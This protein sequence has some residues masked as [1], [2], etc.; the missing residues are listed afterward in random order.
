[1]QQHQQSVKHQVY[2][3]GDKEV[4][5]VRETKWETKDDGSRGRITAWEV[6]ALT[7]DG[8]DDVVYTGEPFEVPAASLSPTHRVVVV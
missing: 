8:R 5:L 4:V 6:H 7:R 1:M 3:V 2:R